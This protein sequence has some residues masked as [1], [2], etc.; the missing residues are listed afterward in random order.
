[1]KPAQLPHLPILPWD[2]SYAAVCCHLNNHLLL[3]SLCF[4]LHQEKIRVRREECTCLLLNGKSNQVS[5]LDVP[6]S[7]LWPSNNAK[8]NK[9]CVLPDYKQ[10]KANH[11]SLLYWD[12]LKAVGRASEI[13]DTVIGHTWDLGLKFIPFP[14]KDRQ[15]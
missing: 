7:S 12:R 9:P 4:L 1:M 8:T 5:D 14:K 15:T 13:L 6:I 11:Q 3:D 2:H 10:L